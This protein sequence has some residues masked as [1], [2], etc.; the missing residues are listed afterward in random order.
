MRRAGIRGAR[1]GG[2]EG[3][4]EVDFAWASADRVPIGENGAVPV[5]EQ[6]SP[7][8]V[9]T[10]WAAARSPWRRASRSTVKWSL[11]SSQML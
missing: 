11:P 2:L 10:T 9:A 6:V 3:G 5:A 4:D 1:I 7:V 8:G